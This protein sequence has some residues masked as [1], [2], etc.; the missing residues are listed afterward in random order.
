M[1]RLVS[2]GLLH[3]FDSG[4]VPSL[5][6]CRLRVPQF[7]SVGWVYMHTRI[8]VNVSQ[9]SPVST[10]ISGSCAAGDPD[11]VP[12]SDPFSL[13]SPLLSQ[14]STIRGC[15][16]D[17]MCSDFCPPSSLL[18]CSCRSTFSTCSSSATPTSPVRRSPSSPQP[19]TFVVCLILGLPAPPGPQL[20][21]NS[22]KL[23]VSLIARCGSCAVGPLLVYLS[24]F[25][26][27]AFM[28]KLNKS[29]GR[30]RVFS[31]G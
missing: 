13:L 4:L 15:R 24:S 8:V 31:L 3:F 16:H 19:R 22:P 28:K 9:V 30:K 27:T 29:L 14:P 18:R 23:T 26:S 25:I 7:Y 21:E 20:L 10:S 2:V 12:G 11:C 6:F 17:D 5:C 1:E